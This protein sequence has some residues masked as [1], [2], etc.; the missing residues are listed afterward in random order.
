MDGHTVQLLRSSFFAS[1]F[2]SPPFTGAAPPSGKRSSTD[3]HRNSGRGRRVRRNLSFPQLQAPW[4]H[5]LRRHQNSARSLLFSFLEPPSSNPRSLSKP[6]STYQ[7]RI[8]RATFP[9]NILLSNL[10]LLPQ[11]DDGLVDGIMAMVIQQRQLL[12]TYFGGKTSCCLCDSWS[13]GL[14]GALDPYHIY[15]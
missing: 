11:V 13:G 15:M 2:T 10:P 7:S 12:V 4:S 1:S 14:N 5:T 6:S 3:R 9:R 8:A